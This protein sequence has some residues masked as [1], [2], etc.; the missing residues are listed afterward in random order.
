MLL[1]YKCNFILF[2]LVIA[3]SAPIMFDIFPSSD[4]Y[5][6][7]IGFLGI[8]G[9]IIATIIGGSLS[10]YYGTKCVPDKTVLRCAGWGC[11]KNQ[12]NLVFPKNF[13]ED[14]KKTYIDKLSTIPTGFKSYFPNSQFSKELVKLNNTLL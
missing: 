10:M 4:T 9:T 8:W 13:Q 14:L 7:G 12:A 2:L 5:L 3:Y 1:K 11:D 6:G